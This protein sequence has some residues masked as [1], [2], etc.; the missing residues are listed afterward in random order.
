MPW[1]PPPA[2]GTVAVTE[3]P[4][5][6]AGRRRSRRGRSRAC[7]AR[8]SCP[9]TCSTRAPASPRRSWRRSSSRSSRPEHGHGTGLGLPIVEEIVR[10][11]RGEVEMLSIAGRGT[12]V[13][14][15]LPAGPDGDAGTGVDRPAGDE[16]RQRPRSRMPVEPQATLGTAARDRRPAHPR[17]HLPPP[18]QPGFTF[19]DARGTSCRTS[20]TWAS[21]TSTPRPS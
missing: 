4:R 8:R 1:T 5:A 9:F 16:P 17:G 13:I 6:G 2:G 3:G 7:R 12:E 15:R 11:H 10:A 14:V 20:T 18:V 19:R 21:P